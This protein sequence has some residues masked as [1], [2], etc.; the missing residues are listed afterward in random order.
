[1]SSIAQTSSA[2][3]TTVT[4]HHSAFPNILSSAGTGWRG[5][6][7]ALGRI[8]LLVTLGIHVMFAGLR[9][10]HL[11]AG[12]SC[13][14]AEGTPMT[15]PTT[16]GVYALCASGGDRVRGEHGWLPATTWPRGR[17]GTKPGEEAMPPVQEISA[18]VSRWRRSRSPGTAPLC[19][20]EIWSA[21]PHRSPPR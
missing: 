9:A 16:S 15:T 11:D 6:S 4:P 14:P 13:L 21:S 17:N 2:S 5:I 7:A 8:A 19:Q 10:N 12:G 20:R 18:T 3:T 1:M